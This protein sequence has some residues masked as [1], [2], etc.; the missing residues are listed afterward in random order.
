LFKQFIKFLK[1]NYYGQ[2][3]ENFSPGF[4]FGVS[5]FPRSSEVDTIDKGLI[6]ISELKYG[7]YVKS[8]DLNQNKWIF[9]KF[10]FY[11]HKDDQIQAEYILIKTSSN[12]I[13]KVSKYHLVA[14]Y[15]TNKIHFVFAS[16]LIINDTL[17]IDDKNGKKH[18]FIV[19]LTKYVDYGA[20]APLLESGTISV[21]NV[22]ASCY[23]NTK[24]HH[25]VHFLFQ[26]II[27]LSK[28]I[29]SNKLIEIN[30]SELP[31]GIFWYAKVMLNL[32]NYI[33]FMNSFLVF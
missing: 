8:Y 3:C 25:F 15:R 24:L 20:Y 23:A 9:S 16:E 31:N 13:L 14:L 18:D 29:D 22:L 7:D 17:I 19:Q 5:C 10:L 33:P 28:Y 12:L 4:G 1:L 32:R 6:S 2:N 30:D 11:L 26:P 27:Q 21:N